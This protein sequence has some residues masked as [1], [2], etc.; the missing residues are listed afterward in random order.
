[1]GNDSDT[2]SGNDLVRGDHKAEQTPSNDGD[3]PFYISGYPATDAST[4]IG[5]TAGVKGKT[6]A[7][8]STRPKGGAS[9][10]ADRTDL[11][12]VNSPDDRGAGKQ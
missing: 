3:T 1:V 7:S 9:R 10:R 12:I 2:W 11:N 6:A 8:S 4:A 5:E